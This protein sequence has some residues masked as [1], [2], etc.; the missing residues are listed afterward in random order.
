M[1]KKKKDKN[2]YILLI[3]NHPFSDIAVKIFN[4]TLVDKNRK[5]IKSNF[6]HKIETNK[7]NIHAI[8]NFQKQIINSKNLAKIKYPINFH[9]GPINFPGRGGYT[10]ALYRNSKY[11]GATAHLMKKKVDT[12]KIIKEV[13]FKIEAYD[14]IE[15]LK[16]KTFITSMNIFYDLLLQFSMRG[17]LNYE[18]KKWSRKPFKIK[19]INKIN[20]LTDKMSSSLKKKIYRSTIYYPFG[21]FKYLKNKKI[22]IKLKKKQN[23]L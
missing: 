22:K 19:D 9:P 5:I 14:N 15:S 23:I 18:K 4:R 1:G 3:D 20:F 16:F 12:G 8:F 21:P 17:K 2:L 13:K 10:W 7:E 6:N 11:Y